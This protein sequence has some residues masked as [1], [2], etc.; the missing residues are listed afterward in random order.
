[1]SVDSLNENIFNDPG[2]ISTTVVKNFLI[3]SFRFDRMITPIAQTHGSFSSLFT[4]KLPVHH[5]A[6]HSVPASALN[7]DL[8][9]TDSLVKKFKDAGYRNT[10]MMDDRTYSYFNAGSTFDKASGPSPGV[11]EAILPHL[12]RSSTIFTF[13]N[14]PFGFAFIPDFRA[15]AAIR[16]YKLS[17]FADDVI[18]EIEASAEDP[19][20]PFL[21]MAHTCALHWPG[22]NIYPFYPRQDNDQMRFS[23]SDR[24]RPFSSLVSSE[25]KNSETALNYSIYTRGIK[26]VQEQFI[27]PI[28]A[29]LEKNGLLKN[30]IVILM[31]D[32]GESFWRSD[33]PFPLSITPAH[34]SNLLFDEQSERAFFA[35]RVPQRRGARIPATVGTIDLF[36]TLGELAAIPLPP[37]DGKS[38]AKLLSNPKANW[39]R[40]YYTETGLWPKA[41]FR[42]QSTAINGSLVQE[43]FQIESKTGNFFVKPEFESAVL[44]QKARA[45]Y[46]N[47]KR[48]TTYPT[49]Y[50]YFQFLC[51][52]SSDPECRQNLISLRPAQAQR[53]SDELMTL[54]A[55]DGDNLIFPSMPKSKLSRGALD[56]KLRNF[57]LTEKSQWLFFQ[58]A[59]ELIFRKH[60]FEEGVKIL[61]SLIDSKFSPDSLKERS[62]ITEMRICAWGIFTSDSAPKGLVR[63]YSESAYLKFIPNISD[64]YDLTQCATML[65][66]ADWKNQIRDQTRN[67][68]LPELG[69]GIYKR[70]LNEQQI[71]KLTNTFSK[72]ESV[73]LQLE[74][75]RLAIEKNEGIAAK[76]IE[77]IQAMPG[78]YQRERFFQLAKLI[79][80]NKSQFSKLREKAASLFHWEFEY[81]LIEELTDFYS[82]LNRSMLA[83]D[84]E[85]AIF[86]IVSQ[87][88]NETL[89]LDVHQR[90]RQIL[91]KADQNF[92]KILSPRLAAIAGKRGLPSISTTG[93]F[94]VN[95]PSI[96]AFYC[97][98]RFRSSRC[99][100]ILSLK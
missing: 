9:L 17:Y 47:E 79:Q 45:I 11:V 10:L 75:Y 12:L 27:S 81:N 46:E 83:H 42:G 40:R 35:M 87:M 48:L 71:E 64:N 92:R 29:Q 61:E 76:L 6:R 25:K 60:S 34:G 38:F 18:R 4:G 1:L 33:S 36:P 65:K 7:T 8:F 77:K 39:K 89:P 16:P 52:T 93:R 58:Y 82:L 100:K 63:M 80:Q 99:S 66:R 51:D 98:Q 28:L 69:I 44:F 86:E 73:L 37:T 68:Q 21:L 72:N 30:S 5:S 50:G 78:F 67:G 2:T 74:I 94:T 62:K 55:S 26:M 49:N 19:A 31:S 23:Y 88:Q 54:S 53:L 43:L 95:L 3:D 97:L 22:E 57:D 14:N 13:F 15:N 41:L 59:N 56:W 85:S 70:N 24:F 91:I 32:H 96:E 90:N 20:K 84:P